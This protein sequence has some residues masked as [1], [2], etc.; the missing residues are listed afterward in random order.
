MSHTVESE[1][2]NIFTHYTHGSPN[3]LEIGSQQMV[4][5]A[6]DTLLLSF[7]HICSQ[8]INIM[9]SSEVVKSNK[10]KGVKRLD[11]EQ[12]LNLL[13]KI[14]MRI[15]PKAETVDQSFEILLSENVLPLASR[16]VHVDIDDILEQPQV[17]NLFEI[18]GPSLESFF[19]TYASQDNRFSASS[20]LK[21]S[22][23]RMSSVTNSMKSAM[24]F[25]NFQKFT[26]D[27]AISGS[28]LSSMEI[29][30]I[31]ISSLKLHPGESI[32]KLSFIEFW[33][34]LVRC[35]LTAY[36][37]ISDAEPSDKFKAFLL[38][39]WRALNSHISSTINRQQ[40]VTTYYGDLM[41]GAMAFNKKFSSQWAQ[42][43][44]KDYLTESK[45]SE[46]R[47]RSVLHRLLK[48]EDMEAIEAEQHHPS[49]IEELYHSFSE[50]RG[51]M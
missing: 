36:S 39:M 28:I 30:N 31:Y 42:D 48:K 44:F 38:Y 7:P 45:K 22:T 50:S 33:E 4:K 26:T 16:R 5:L 46:E 24:S 21:Q 19:E 15:Y 47:G 41:K 40:G 9:F 51:P 18:Y 12:F 29:E 32:R 27:F 49:K 43:D 37:K 1:L 17:L 2:F 10:G 35:S 13:V 3:P 34:A 25:K 11:Y 20:P 6:K 23:R 8:D 14:S